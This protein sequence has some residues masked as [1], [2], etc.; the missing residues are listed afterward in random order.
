MLGGIAV[1]AA[2]PVAA[3]AGLGAVGYGIAKSAKNKRKLEEEN[4]RL[5]DELESKK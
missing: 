1:V 3:A 5:K 2:A 4:K